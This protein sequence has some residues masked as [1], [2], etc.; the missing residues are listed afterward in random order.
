MFDCANSCMIIQE[1][2][3]VKTVEYTDAK[4]L[5]MD[6]TLSNPLAPNNTDINNE[7]FTLTVYPNPTSG[8]I[9]IINPFDINSVLTIYDLNGK[10]VYEKRLTKEINIVDTGLEKG[11][12]LINLSDGKTILYTKLTVL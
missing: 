11:L 2:H 7:T 10:L 8:Q 3:F 12:Y 9:N 6:K 4:P 5:S 1:Y